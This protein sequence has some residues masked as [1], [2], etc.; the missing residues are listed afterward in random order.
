MC[1]FFSILSSF[2]VPFGSS[3]LFLV[4]TIIYFVP[5]YDILIDFTTFVLGMLDLCLVFKAALNTKTSFFLSFFLSST[6]LFLSF[7]FT[8]LFFTRCIDA[9]W[10]KVIT[11]IWN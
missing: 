8:L 5:E 6:C 3:M 11:I 1:Y 10:N 9:F 4:F 7:K 2:A